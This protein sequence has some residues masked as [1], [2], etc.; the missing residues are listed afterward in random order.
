MKHIRAF[1][2][3]SIL[4]ALAI[5]STQ[6]IA[7]VDQEREEIRLLIVDETKSFS[8]TMRVGALAK[9]LD[10]SGMVDLAVEMID[11]ESSYA[12]PLADLST[13]E[14]PY[15]LILIIPKGIDDTTIANIW[16]V[17]RY[18]EKTMP[19]YMLLASLSEIVNQV[20]KGN[21]VATD[22]S[23]DLWPASYASLY[24]TEGW[25]R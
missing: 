24:L 19:Q 10:Q 8:S 11:V 17:S 23:E 21:A 2:I 9:V 13:P 15:D 12:D 16:L 7:Q 3:T 20:F 1:I 6:A 22:V 5:I 14:Q 18:Y 25:L 4:V